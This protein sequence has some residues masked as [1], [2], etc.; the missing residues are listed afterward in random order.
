MFYRFRL[1][2]AEITSVLAQPRTGPIILVM[3]ACREA[4]FRPP[5]WRSIKHARHTKVKPSAPASVR[6]CCLSVGQTRSRGQPLQI[7]MEF[8]RPTG[9]RSAPAPTTASSSIWRLIYWTR[10]RVSKTKGRT[11]GSSSISP[12]TT[13]PGL[14]RSNS[15]SRTHWRRCLSIMAGEAGA[16]PRWAMRQE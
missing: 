7:R 8:C 9:R 11:P 13:P 10:R 1:W 3:Q 6:T 2:S 15:R 14:R 12:S 5:P 16:S 4:R